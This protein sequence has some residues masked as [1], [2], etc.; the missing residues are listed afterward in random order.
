MRT[1]AHAL[2][3]LLSLWSLCGCA[4]SGGPE[5]TPEG[6]KVRAVVIWAGAQTRGY[7]SIDP[8]LP[9]PPELKAL[10]GRLTLD[11]CRLVK[12]YEERNLDSSSRLPGGYPPV[13][14]IRNDAAK[15]GGS[16]VLILCYPV[17]VSS[18]QLYG[19]D[20]VNEVYACDQGTPKGQ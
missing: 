19:M 15:I 1:G 9:D 13:V 11:G 2:R 12:R 7:E 20:V 3:S 6:E 16:V 17:R 5:L 10:K 14:K 4:T 8:I 18:L